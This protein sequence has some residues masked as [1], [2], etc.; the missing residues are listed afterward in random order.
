VRP[1][2]RSELLLA[3]TLAVGIALGLAGGGWLARHQ[4]ERLRDLRRPPGF[5]AHLEDVIAPRDEAQRAEVHRL[6]EET[7]RGNDRII[8]DANE[9]LRV[10]MDSLRASLDPLLDG[11]QRGR[12]DRELR[13]LRSPFGPPPRG[14]PPPPPPRGP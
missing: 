14:G 3:V 4:R 9:T 8:R 10:R 12:L 1:A 7:A 6:L 5:V 2:I 13:G 11:D